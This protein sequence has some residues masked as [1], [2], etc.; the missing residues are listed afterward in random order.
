M[1]IKRF[2]LIPVLAIGLA[3]CQTTGQKQTGGTLLGAAA[4][5]LLGSQFGQGTGQ[6]AFTAA[7]TIL[8]AFV[9][10]QIGQSLDRTDRLFADRAVQQAAAAPVGQTITWSNPD[11]GNYGTV[12]PVRD[13]QDTNT[14]AFCREYQTTVTVGGRSESAFGTACL[15]PDGSWKIVG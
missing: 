10:N 3:A 1:K 12:T 11:S 14:G 2:W 6:L 15:Q 13:G 7:G 8:G 5:G 4:G 9:G